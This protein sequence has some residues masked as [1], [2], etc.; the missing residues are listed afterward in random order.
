[1]NTEEMERF[2][3]RVSSPILVKTEMLRN[4]FNFL[5]DEIEKLQAA[6]QKH[7]EV[8]TEYAIENQKLKEQIKGYERVN[9][10]QAMKIVELK[11]K[12]L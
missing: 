1:M 11:N 5:L 2:R 4:N 10:K 6:N 8:V 12:G 9:H 7:I 3:T